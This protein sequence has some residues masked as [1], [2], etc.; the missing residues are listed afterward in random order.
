MVNIGDLNFTKSMVSFEIHKIIT[1]FFLYH[2]DYIYN[3]I[4]NKYIGSYDNYKN[5]TYKLFIC[6][7]IKIP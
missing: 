5:G 1:T 7:I 6:K 3:Y 2:L 4:N